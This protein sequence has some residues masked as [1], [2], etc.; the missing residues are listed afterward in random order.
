MTTKRNV[1]RSDFKLIAK[2]RFRREHGTFFSISFGTL[3]GQANGAPKIA[4][5]VSKKTVARAVDRNRIKRM[6]REAAQ[7]CLAGVMAPRTLV[8]YAKRPAAGASFTMIQEDIKRLI[9][10][11]LI[12]QR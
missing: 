3:P 10:K 6:C 12:A 5:V 8:F 7:A 11:I 1:T 4:C 2:A 9:G